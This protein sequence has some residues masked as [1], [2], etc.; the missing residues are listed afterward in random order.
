MIYRWY[1][2]VYSAGQGDIGSALVASESRTIVVDDVDVDQAASLRRKNYVAIRRQILVADRTDRGMIEYSK[3]RRRTLRKQ[4][5]LWDSEQVRMKLCL[6]GELP[7]KRR[8]TIFETVIVSDLL[9]R[10]IHPCGI[11]SFPSFLRVLQR[12]PLAIIEVGNGDIVGV[13]GFEVKTLYSA[14]G[15]CENIAIG[16]F[17]ALD[18]RWRAVRRWWLFQMKELW[19]AVGVPWISYGGDDGYIDIRYL[20]IITDKLRWGSYIVDLNSRRSIFFRCPVVD[21]CDVSRWRVFPEEGASTLVRLKS[22]WTPIEDEMSWRF[23]L[24]PS[25]GMIVQDSMEGC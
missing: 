23:R 17:M 18:P 16:T 24:L 22:G 5:L 11:I 10:G 13:A 12:G 21:C 2:T 4:Q 19:G 9:R 7:E 6:S 25:A 14:Q 1:P 20:P 3:S 15:G 8:Q